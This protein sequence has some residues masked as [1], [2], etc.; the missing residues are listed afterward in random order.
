MVV[1]TAAA[2]MLAILAVATLAHPAVA[3]ESTSAK[4]PVQAI[5]KH[6]EIVFA[7]QSFTTFYSCDS[8]E[9]KI[10]RILGAVG[11]GRNLM[12]RTK[13]CFHAHEIA[14]FPSVQITVVSAVEA[15]PEALADRDRNRST[16]ELVARV[17]GE[18]EELRQAEEQFA[19]QW[20]EVPLS[21]GKLFLDPGDCEL[22][23]Q[24]K[25]RV[26][27]Q[28]GVRVVQDEVRC[29]SNQMALSQPKLVVEALFEMPKPDEAA[30]TPAP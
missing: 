16:R 29:T 28:L 6:H 18:S 3:Q 22:I 17:R 21:R 8:L 4:P 7:Y 25:D 11:A 26:F 9:R 14:R 2:W 24:L 27:P 10:K 15:T 30:E 23:D 12:L 19:G 13:G 20:R 1:R 5:W